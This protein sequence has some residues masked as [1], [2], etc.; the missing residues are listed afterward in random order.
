MFA[1]P[2]EYEF[3]SNTLTLC[4]QPDEGIHLKF[5]T[6]V[7]DTSADTRSVDLEY[8]YRDVF[9][10]KA[11]PEAYERLLLDALHGDASLFTR[12]DRNELAWEI[13]GPILTAWE[14]QIVRRFPYMNQAVGV[15]LRQMRY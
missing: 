7:P 13:L 9:G 12:S 8:H 14:R 4:L 6:K 3:T 10:E 1:L 15:H 5:E 11:I 2:D